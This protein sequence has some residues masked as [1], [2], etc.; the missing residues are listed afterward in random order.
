MQPKL[1]TPPTAE[2]LSLAEAYQHLRA[3]STELQ[4]A[5]IWR[6][7]RAARAAC[8]IRTQNQVIAARWQLVLDSFPGSLGGAVSYIPWGRT[9]GLPAN[10]ILIPKAP[11]LQVVSITWLDMAGVTQTLTAGQANDYVTDLGTPG[12][13]ARITPPFGKVWP[14]NVMP[15]AGAI[16]VT[17]DAGHA[18]L[19]TFDASAD[20]VYV[21]GWKTLA[22]ND[23]VRFTNRDRAAVGDGALPGGISALTDYYV[24]SVVSADKY[25]LSASS[26]GAL[27]DITSAG[28]GEHFIGEIPAGLADW[29]ALQLGTLYENRESISVDTRITQVELPSD[30][31]DGLLDPYRLVLY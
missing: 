18:A 23:A 9:Y 2:P 13:P 12:T 6:A 29:M 30:F 19:A 21:P 11:V 24:R 10:A 28:A 22:V 8:E 27:L 15:Q 7:I 4:D 17:F 16:V 14:A 26:G 31:T 25:T 5:K 1:V 3:A 20:T